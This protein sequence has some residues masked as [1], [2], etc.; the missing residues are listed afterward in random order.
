VARGAAFGFAAAGLVVLFELALRTATLVRGSPALGSLI[1]GLLI[2]ALAA[3][4]DELLLRGVVLRATRG[5][6]PTWAAVLACGGASTAAR[7]GMAGGDA[8]TLACEAL[9]GVALGGLWVRDRGAWMAWAANA[10]WMWSE[11]SLFRGAL[12][13][14]RSANEPDASVSAFAVLAVAAVAA[15]LGTTGRPAEPPQKRKARQSG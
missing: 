2:S 1:V 12:L 11:G 6:L 8:I 13:D 5:L 7:I 4:R 9:R 3:V 14:V 10:T 15:L